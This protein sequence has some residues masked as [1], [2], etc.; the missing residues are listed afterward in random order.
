MSERHYTN[1]DLSKK[2]KSNFELVTYAISLAKGMIESGRDSRVSAESQNYASLILEEIRTGKDHLDEDSITLVKGKDE[3][4]WED[5][6]FDQSPPVL[7]VDDAL[8]V[9]KLYVTEIEE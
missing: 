7:K 4:E 9:G 8:E 2:F 3:E 1:E 5:E 6:E